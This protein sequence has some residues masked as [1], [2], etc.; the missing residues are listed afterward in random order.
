MDTFTETSRAPD[1]AVI[2]VNSGGH[3]QGPSSISEADFHPNLTTIQQYI[4]GDGVS[5]GRK[6]GKTSRKPRIS[7][8]IHYIE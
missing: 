3:E 2:A 8:R 5:S 7:V 6:S 4:V 1:Q